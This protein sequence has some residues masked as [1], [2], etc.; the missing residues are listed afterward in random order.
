M[1]RADRPEPCV[2]SAALMSDLERFWPSRRADDFDE[3]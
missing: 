3:D 2:P 1:P